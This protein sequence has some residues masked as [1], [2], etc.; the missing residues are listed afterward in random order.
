ME[1]IVRICDKCDKSYAFNPN[2]CFSEYSS[3]Y[4]KYCCD[5]IQNNIE[6][7]IKDYMKIKYGG[8]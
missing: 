1:V 5:M 7:K 8:L 6:N 2:R 3:K 4:C